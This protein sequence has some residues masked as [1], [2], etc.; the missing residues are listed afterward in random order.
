MYPKNERDALVYFM[1]RLD[2]EMIAAILDDNKLYLGLPKKEF[3][4]KLRKAFREFEIAGD[5]QLTIHEGRCGKCN[6]G[7][8]GFTFCGNQGHYMNVLFE[9]EG[10]KV[11]DIGD[12]CEFITPSEVSGKRIWVKINPLILPLDDNDAEFRS[13]FR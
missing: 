10:D 11:K 2:I 9:M 12:C 6:K 3:I 4:G 8:C 5:T 1:A 13:D 7:M